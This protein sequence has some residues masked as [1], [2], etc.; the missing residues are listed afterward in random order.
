MKWEEMV[1]AVDGFI[2]MSLWIVRV[3]TWEGCKDDSAY[4]CVCVGMYRADSCANVA[5]VKS[6][7]N[8]KVLN[9]LMIRYV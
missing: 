2:E 7:A 8:G 6:N 5:P 9:N 3:K 1:G 4:L